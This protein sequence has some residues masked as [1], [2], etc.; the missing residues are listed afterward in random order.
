MSGH[1]H[2]HGHGRGCGCAGEHEP[3]ERGLE[4]DLYGRIDVEKMQCLNESRDGDGKLVFKPW[5]QRSD[6]EKVTVVN[7][8]SPGKWCWVSPPSENTNRSDGLML[9]LQIRSK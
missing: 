1:G 2:G 8:L 3:P 4:D 5:D 6:R 9:T 7:I